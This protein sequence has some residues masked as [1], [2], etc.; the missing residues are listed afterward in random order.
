MM[1][2]LIQL[3]PP[4]RSCTR[5]GYPLEAP[6]GGDTHEVCIEPSRVEVD[7]VLAEVARCLDCGAS[8]VI[9]VPSVDIDGEAGVYV[10]TSH[11]PNCPTFAQ[12]RASAR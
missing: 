5:C 7:P 11:D 9:V 8:E 2:N 6:T 1:D 3:H 10:T 12:R 4:T